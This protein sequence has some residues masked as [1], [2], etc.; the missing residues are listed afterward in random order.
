MAVNHL[1]WRRQ[2]QVLHLEPPLHEDAY[3]SFLAI[4]LEQAVNIASTKI[5]NIQ[6]FFD[7]WLYLDLFDLINGVSHLRADL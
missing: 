4:E 1:I 2:C 7:E 6:L 5:C 3:E